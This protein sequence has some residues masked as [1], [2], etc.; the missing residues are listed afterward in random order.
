MSE[1]TLRLNQNIVDYIKGFEVPNPLNVTFTERQ[2]FNGIWL[3]SIRSELN[4]RHFSNLLNRKVFGNASRRFGKKLKMLVVRER[5]ITHRHHLHTIIET[6]EH[7]ETIH[8]KKLLHSLWMECDFGYH[9]IHIE[10]PTSHKREVGW[11][12]YMMKHHQL[13]GFEF[14]ID[15]TNSTV[16]APC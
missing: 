13:D 10:K 16:L 1:G 2:R 12:K 14:S 3:D 8:F 9:H 7:I 5:S 15:W 6:P 11:L 4:Y